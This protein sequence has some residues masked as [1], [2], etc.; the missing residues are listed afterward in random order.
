MMH[1][2]FKLSIL[3][4]VTYLYKKQTKHYKQVVCSKSI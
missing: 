4:R 2:S 1:K 3:N